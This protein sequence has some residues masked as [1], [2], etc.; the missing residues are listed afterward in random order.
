MLPLLNRSNAGY[1]WNLIPHRF[2]Q[3]FS[4]FTPVSPLLSP[5]ERLSRVYGRTEAAIGFRLTSALKLSAEDQTAFDDKTGSW[6][7][8]LV[9]DTYV[10]STDERA[11]ST[12]VSPV[13]SNTRLV[14]NSSLSYH[15]PRFRVGRTI[16]QNC[17]LQL[18][19]V[20]S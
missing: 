18:A 19:S 4:F 17:T 11:L 3:R 8:Q 20:I 12:L 9:S 16:N 1:S 15:E 2:G 10:S 5:R 7:D 14:I 13:R 6:V